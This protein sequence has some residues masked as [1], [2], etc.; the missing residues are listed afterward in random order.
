MIDMNDQKNEKLDLYPY[1]SYNP[2]YCTFNLQG[3]FLLYSEVDSYFNNYD[4]KI[5]WIYS[6]TTK[7]INGRV[8]EFTRYLKLLN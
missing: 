8:K 4:K 3:E 7:I 2:H 6:T 5:V 1:H